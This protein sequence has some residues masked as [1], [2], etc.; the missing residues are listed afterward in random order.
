MTPRDLL[1]VADELLAGS[2][3]AW[4][5]SAVSRAY[6]AAFHAARQVLQGCGFEIPRAELAHAYLWLRLANCGHPDVQS[7]GAELNEL[8]RLRNWADYDLD[9]SFGHG[10]TVNQVQAASAVLQLLET[11]PTT[12]AVLANIADAMRAYERDV[13]GQVT[14]RA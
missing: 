11:L 6:Y 5:R 1:D 13:L 8:R 2:K 9:Q 14:W 10:I 12:P 3:E 7:A 4:W